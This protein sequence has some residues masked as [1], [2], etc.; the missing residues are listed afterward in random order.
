MSR[1]RF[2]AIGCITVVSMAATVVLLLSLSPMGRWP[3][4]VLSLTLAAALILLGFW[5]GPGIPSSRLR[6][7]VELPTGLAP[8][9]GDAPWTMDEEEL[10][11]V[12]EGDL[13]G[14]WSGTVRLGGG[15][16]GGTKPIRELAQEGVAAHHAGGVDRGVHGRWNLRWATHERRIV[17]LRIALS[18]NPVHVR[19]LPSEH[20][21]GR[22]RVAAV[23][24]IEHDIVHAALHLR[25]FLVRVDRHERAVFDASLSYEGRGAPRLTP[26][27]DTAAHSVELRRTHHF[28]RGVD[29]RRLSGVVLH[30]A[31]LARLHPFADWKSPPPEVAATG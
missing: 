10:P 14:V 22:E 25:V 7:E 20:F 4:A 8:D 16:S 23:D 28:R 18:E 1:L 3:M 21:A 6:Q 29:G 13:S 26:M 17:P 24:V 15:G 9:A 2:F 19:L 11:D 12:R 27:D 30:S 5:L 31:P